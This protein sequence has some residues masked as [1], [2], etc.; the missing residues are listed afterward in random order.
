MTSVTLRTD[1]EKSSPVCTMQ[2]VAG[3]VCCPQ[4]RKQPVQPGHSLVSLSFEGGA[5]CGSTVSVGRQEA[6]RVLILGSSSLTAIGE[7]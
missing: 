3:L 4:D 6:E 1:A 5:W 7:F 2:C